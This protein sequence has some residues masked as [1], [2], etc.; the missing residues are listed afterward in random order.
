MGNRFYPD[1]K[2]QEKVYYELVS[3]YQGRDLKKF[4][5]ECGIFCEE[6]I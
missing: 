1:M 5:F 2:Y 3:K 6:E 4:D